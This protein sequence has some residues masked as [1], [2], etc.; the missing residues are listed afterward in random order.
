MV[1]SP[2]ATPVE[3]RIAQLESDVAR[4]RAEMSAVK[5]DIQ[6]LD[7]KLD[8]LDRAD[9]WDERAFNLV[10]AGMVLAMIAMMFRR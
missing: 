9:V 4:M 8:A 3:H 5:G 2:E 6:R 1:L 10:R 7:W